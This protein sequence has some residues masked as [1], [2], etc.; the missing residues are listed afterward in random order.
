MRDMLMGKQKAQVIGAEHAMCGDHII[1]SN[2][3]TSRPLEFVYE[4]IGGWLI[5]EDSGFFS[6]LY[7]NECQ[8]SK[9]FSGRLIELPMVDG[10]V[11]LAK[12]Q[13][14][15]G[16][17]PEYSQ[18]VTKVGCLSL[19]EKK[20]SNTFFSMWVDNQILAD[21]YERLLKAV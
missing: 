12:G 2:L 11:T 10:S 1:G 9:A 6:F 7:L 16:V 19:E 17:H 18:L 3:I 4:R 13:W 14:W 20:T 5:G 21:V 8:Y 15:D